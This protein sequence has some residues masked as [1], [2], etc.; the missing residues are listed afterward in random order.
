MERWTDDKPL[1]PMTR[2]A[3][4]DLIDSLKRTDDSGEHWLM[5]DVFDAIGTSGSRQMGVEFNRAFT[6][7][8][9]QHC[10]DSRDFISITHHAKGPGRPRND[11]RM[12]R[13]GFALLVM[14]CGIR[15]FGADRL[16]A[17]VSVLAST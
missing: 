2:D 7:G 10:L 4:L 14:T 1:T 11:W 12:T 5:T 17:A 16:R 3:A 8:A 9:Q 13:R 6:L 15:S